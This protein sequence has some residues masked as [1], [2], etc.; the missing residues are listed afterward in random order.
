MRPSGS[1][2]QPVQPDALGH[3]LVDGLAGVQRTGRRPGAPSAPGCRNARRPGSSSPA[4]RRRTSTSPALG[5]CSPIRVRA[6][7]VLPEPDSPTSATISPRAYGQV[8]AVEG[9]RR[10]PAT[11]GEVDVRRR[12]PRSAAARS[13]ATSAG[14]H[15]SPTRTQAAARS[16]VERQQL[17][18]GLAALVERPRAPGREGAPGGARAGRAG[19]RPGRRARSGRPGHR[20]RGNGAGQG[21]GVGVLRIGEHLLGAARLHDAAGVHHQRRG[22]RR[23]RA[24]TG[25]G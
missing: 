1:L 13:A 3:G 25:R 11:G 4:G 15:G 19:R 7:V 23:R 24:P 12:A 21:A 5:R 10:G 16:A 2:G 17:R 14:A 6:S 20:S 22:R 9:T 8:G 18:L